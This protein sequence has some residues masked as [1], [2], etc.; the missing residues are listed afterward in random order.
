MAA[1]NGRFSRRTFTALGLGASAGLLAATKSATAQD[2]SPE[3]AETGPFENTG[4]TEIIVTADQYTFSPSVP[5]AMGEGWYIITLVNETESVADANLGL[6]PEGTTGSALS[7]ALST[8]FQGEGGELPEWWSS[9]TFAGGSVAGPGESTSSLVYLIPGKWYLFSTNPASTQSPASFLI[10]TAEELEANYG[11]AATP[12]ATPEVAQG[13]TPE[14]A[15]LVSPEGVTAA[16]SIEITENQIVANGAPTGGEQLLQITNTSDQVRHVII[17]Q[18]EETVDAESVTS[19]A[20]SW[21]KGEE[22]NATVAGGV[23]TLSP[24]WTAFTAIDAQP[25]NYILFSALPDAN[26]GL[27]IDNGLITTFS[28]E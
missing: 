20:R 7:S 17:L 23:G 6:L 28:V 24:G 15:G 1:H 21:I 11:I 5:G 16:V 14:I 19:I 13:A 4:Y 26:G 27:Q 18:T 12:E 10:Q 9:A 2:A 3:V 22:T 8:A 25:G